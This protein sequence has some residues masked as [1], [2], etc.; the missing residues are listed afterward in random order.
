[1]SF[2]ALSALVEG[3]KVFCVVDAS[4]N[5]SKMATDITIARVTQAVAIPT[6]TF[7]VLA[8]IMG[9]WN[10][11]DAYDFAGVMVENVVPIYRA[12]MEN[13]YKAQSVAQNGHETELNILNKAK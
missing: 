2:P 12:L 6:D 3:Y 5:W 4:G 10:R 7:A 9:T 13:Y 1:M 11:V 8:E